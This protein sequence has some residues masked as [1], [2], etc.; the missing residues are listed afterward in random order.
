MKALVGVDL[1]DTYKGAET[2]C[3]RLDFQ[4]QKWIFANVAPLLSAYSPGL[5]PVMIP[6]AD[7]TDAL[8]NAGRK[9][10]EEAREIAGVEEIECLELIED[11]NTAAALMR[12]AEERDADLIV[13]GSGKPRKGFLWTLGSVSRALSYGAKQSLLVSKQGIG[14]DGPL[15]A[16]FATDHSQYA[17][18]AL[19]TLIE[20][21]PRGLRRIDVL[22]AYDT[23]KETLAL[24]RASTQVQLDFDRWVFENCRKESEAA[25]Q[26]LRTIAP[27]VQIIIQQGRPNEVIAE[28]MKETGADLL[29]LGA[30]GHGFVQ[31]LLVGSTSL[32]QL[33]A[34][35]YPVLLIRLP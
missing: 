33:V 27:E 24:L 32:H 29:I 20:W 1:E 6:V 22:T 16:V 12:I 10:L 18:C 4:N 30:Q 11:G 2:L 14:G 28:V 21:A 34:E 7:A 23:G 25:A 9:A 8:H 19:E 15:H 13:A 35:P 26:Q 3:K 31:R 17:K 5:S